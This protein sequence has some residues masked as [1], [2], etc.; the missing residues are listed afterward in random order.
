MTGA[1]IRFYMPGSEDGDINHLNHMSYAVFEGLARLATCFHNLLQQAWPDA[2]NGNEQVSDLRF[3]SEL[4]ALPS[5]SSSNAKALTAEA[6]GASMGPGLFA[7]ADVGEYQRV[8]RVRGKKATAFLSRAST[9]S[10]LL[11]GATFILPVE[12]ILSGPQ[13]QL[14]TVRLSVCVYQLCVCILYLYRLY[15][16]Y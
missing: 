3:R 2:C 5:S 16:R 15:R 6:F 1:C 10:N 7:E 11:I 14:K 13:S 8:Q 4:Y 12:R 9:K